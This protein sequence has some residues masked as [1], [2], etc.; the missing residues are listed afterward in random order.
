MIPIKEVHPCN[1]AKIAKNFEG[2]VTSVLVK[3]SRIIGADSQRILEDNMY[4]DEVCEDDFDIVF[5]Y[6][7]DSA[8]EKNSKYFHRKISVM[9]TFGRDFPGSGE[10]DKLNRLGYEKIAEYFTEERRIT[11]RNFH[12]LSATFFVSLFSDLINPSTKVLEIGPGHGWLYK[13]VSPVCGSYT[14]LDISV[15]MSKINPRI[16]KATSSV[17]CINSPSEIYDLV[18]AS[19]ADSYFYPEAICEIG[20]VL[21]RNGYFAFSIPA[22]EWATALRRGSSDIDKTTFILNSGENAKVYSFTFPDKKLVELLDKAGFDSLKIHS[23]TGAGLSG[24][25]ISDAITRAAENIRKPLNALKIVTVAIFQKRGE[26][27]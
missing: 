9:Q 12:E 6:D 11:T 5:F 2:K 17:R 4:Y 18:V 23:L 13:T 22:F 10:I 15:S 16:D 27:N 21:K 3:T 8:P 20:R 24:N 26:D 25:E 19:L 1:Y 7:I 14:C